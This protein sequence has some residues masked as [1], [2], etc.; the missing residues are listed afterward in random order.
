MSS[1]PTRQLNVCSVSMQAGCL[2]HRLLSG[3]AMP[4]QCS[5]LLMDAVISLGSFTISQS[6][7]DFWPYSSPRADCSH[8]MFTH[9]ECFINA[10]SIKWIGETQSLLWINPSSFYKPNIWGQKQ[11][12][13]QRSTGSALWVTVVY[14]KSYVPYH[15]PHITD[16]TKA[17]HT[18]ICI[19]SGYRLRIAPWHPIKVDTDEFI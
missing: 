7:L 16:Y 17:P 1:I 10:L 12:S 13:V 6:R 3:S 5:H 8:P 14:C 15:Q 18:S 19:I 11:Y 4:L 9:T 2:L